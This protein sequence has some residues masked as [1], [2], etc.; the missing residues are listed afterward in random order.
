LTTTP[1]QR[2]SAIKQ[3]QVLTDVIPAGKEYSKPIK[4]S[5]IVVGTLT[6]QNPLGKKPTRID[7]SNAPD[8][9][10][11]TVQSWDN[12]SIVLNVTSIGSVDFIIY[13]G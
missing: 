3:A 6:L 9:A 10:Q 12:K 2:I 4:T 8:S 13:A 7:V 11:Y 1:Q 5:A